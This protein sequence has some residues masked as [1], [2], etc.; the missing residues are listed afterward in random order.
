MQIEGLERQTA[1]LK[2]RLNKVESTRNTAFDKQLEH[3]EQQRQELNGRVDR[4]M[5]DNLAKDKQIATMSN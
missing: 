1:D 3:F 2:E 5:Q 4:L